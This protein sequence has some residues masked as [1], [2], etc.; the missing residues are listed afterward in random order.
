LK[1]GDESAV[2]IRAVAEAVG[3]TAPSIYLHFADKDELLV[4]VCEVQFR[5][6]DDFVEEAVAGISDPLVRL[7]VRGKA[8]VQFG[9][10]YPEHY[11]ILFM[12]KTAEVMARADERLS[13]VSGFGRLVENVEACLAA[14]V[15]RDDDPLLV[16]NGLWALV[17]GVTSLTIS[18]PGFPSVGLDRLVDHV[19]GVYGLGL[20]KDR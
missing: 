6:F 3:V 2:S 5:K 12:N 16:A 14:G 11:R 8:Y 1:T 17:H 9:V 4:A 18:V 19:C 20:M 10:E 15:L 13:A 7:T